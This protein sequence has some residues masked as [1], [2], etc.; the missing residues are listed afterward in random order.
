LALPVPV[1]VLVLLCFNGRS[2]K[3]RRE[4]PA[5]YCCA[6][7]RGLKLLFAAACCASGIYSA[8]KRGLKLLFAAACCASG[9]PV[10]CGV[11]RQAEP[12]SSP[13]G[14]QEGSEGAG[15]G[16]SASLL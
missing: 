4:K 12:G 9:A 5:V 1:L 7:R 2:W 13:N 8:S 6:S 3:H 10:A 11:C 14:V 16:V 15:Q